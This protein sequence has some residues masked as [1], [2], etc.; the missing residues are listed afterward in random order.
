M[1]AYAIFDVDIRDMNQY[2][3]FMQQV[4]PAVEAAGGKYL[5][6]GGVHKVYEGDWHP[7]RLVVFEFPSLEAFDSFYQ[8][9]VY[10]E[11]KPLRDA[12]SSARLVAV[13]GLAA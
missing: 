7:R 4:K 8:G 5:A 11:L 2:Q 1:S 3:A 6:R 12:C 10:R 13:E 9:P